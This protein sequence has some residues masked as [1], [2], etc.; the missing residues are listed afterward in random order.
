M[1]EPAGRKGATVEDCF[2]GRKTPTVKSM[3]DGAVSTPDCDV[4]VSDANLRLLRGKA[5]YGRGATARRTARLRRTSLEVGL[6]A[7]R[8][9]PTQPGVCL[10]QL[11]SPGAF[12]RRRYGTNRRRRT[13]RRAHVRIWGAVEERPSSPLRCYLVRSTLR[14]VR[15]AVPAGAVGPVER[16]RAFGRSR[17]HRRPAAFIGS[18][19][20]SSVTRTTTGAVPPGVARSGVSGHG[21][22]GVAIASSRS[23]TTLHSR[24]SLPPCRLR[25]R[26]PQRPAPR[27][28]RPPARL[29]RPVP[30]GFVA[31][32][33]SS[34]RGCNCEVGVEVVLDKGGLGARRRA[35]GV[36]AEDVDGCPGASGPPAIALVEQPGSSPLARCDQPR[37]RGGGPGRGRR[38]Q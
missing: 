33:V 18:D 36:A 3:P 1:G 37:R 2:A 22:V 25:R 27:R 17:D 19:P 16:Y 13:T 10:D 29:P 23:E 28:R 4:G 35:R 31:L 26:A 8:N 9:R 34:D 6:R 20:A 7:R 14:A 38:S 21:G 12:A 11:S 30:E 15:M 5:N 24:P 32:A